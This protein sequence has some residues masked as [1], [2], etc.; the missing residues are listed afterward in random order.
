MAVI[1]PLAPMRDNMRAFYR[2][3]GRR[4]P[5]G[6]VVE[7]E[8]LVAAIVP[9]CPG[10]SVVNAVVYERASELEAAHDELAAAYERARVRAWT[11][12]VPESDRAAAELLASRGHRLD[13]RP[14]AMTLNLDEIR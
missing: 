3:L 14:R 12:W 4:S 1:D 7:R 10:R 8:G 11:V 5:G 6:S 13:A 9:S 2:L